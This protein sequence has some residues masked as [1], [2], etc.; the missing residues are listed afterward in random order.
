MRK[1]DDHVTLTTKEA[2][3]GD[4]SGRV[5]MIL[6][7]GLAVAIIGLFAILAMWSQG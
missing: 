3:S 1:E 2:R 6:I 7:A 4:T 5:R